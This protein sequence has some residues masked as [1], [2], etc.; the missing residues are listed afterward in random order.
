MKDNQHVHNTHHVPE[1]SEHWPP[2]KR[3]NHT[4][5][6]DEHAGH[7]TADFRKRFWICLIITIPI[8]LL[9][10]MIQDLIGLGDSIRFQGDEYLLFTFASL[11][12]FYGGFPFL[13]G[14]TREIRNKQ[15]GMMAL[16]SLAIS[17]AYIFSAAV[18]FGSP[19]HQLYWELA[20]LI[21]IMLL[22][23]WIE[24]KSI[25]GA[26]QAL[27]KLV[28]LMPSEA[29]LIKEDGSIQDIPIS[30]LKHSHKVLIKPG[31]K[32]PTDGKIIEGSS[33]VN[34]AMLTGESVPVEKKIGDD[35]FGG[36]VNGESA[37]TIQV[38]KTGNET[39]LS[40][41]IELVKQ[42][43][44]SRSK[45]QDVANRAAFFLT[46]IAL[47]VGFIT[48][49]T[50]ILIG[51]TFDFAI[52]RMVTVMVI[53][54][55]HALGLAVPLVVAVSTT[56]SASSGLL[57]RDRT[58]FE[59]SKDLSAVVF[60]KTGTLT[61][62]E[63]G[64]TDVVSLGE[65]SES[66]LLK[67]AASLESHSEHPIA[68]GIV[69]YAKQNN[70]GFSSPDSF[71]A[72]A[73]KGAEAQVGETNIKVVSP[74]YLRDKN[75]A[76]EDF[77]I[78]D[79]R[80]QT[81]TVVF[82]LINDKLAG[83]IALADIIREESLHALKNLHDLGI[84]SMMLTGDAKAVAEAVAKQLNMDDFFAEVLPHE[85]SEKIK[86][87][88]ARGLTVAMVGDGVNDAPALVEADVGIA[89]GAGTDVAIESADIIL[90]R[91]DPRDVP[92]II[93]LANA[94]Y[95]KMVQN[96]WWAAGYNIVAIP[97]AAGVLYKYGILLSPALGA[98]FMSVST[99]LVAFNAQLLWKSKNRLT[100]Q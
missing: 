26:S 64:V 11:V 71:T 40:Q 55:P 19:G 93:A 90:V 41:V 46:L 78:S 79:L 86:Q 34:Q 42:A 62:G 83:A 76:W 69:K 54:C 67:F 47:S 98:V 88:K 92:A 8:L 50:W 1:K 89:I 85:K 13:K 80:K 59:K 61:K 17:V 48:L 15:L 18:T 60:D 68:Q 72:I 82:V 9:D 66:E 39:Y 38:T 22:G 81:K 4:H 94:T 2:Y 65:Y 97:L 29:H 21:D 74:G 99:I 51:S 91:S 12:Y 73:G 56:L 95:R 58:A 14:L 63:F 100:L 84:K 24:M 36:S 44:A 87:V 30:E 10:P 31:E 70:I 96:L 53:A 75:I 52:E 3:D 6:I 20:T 7:S 33:S 35:V 32:I 45:T 28:R 43:Q 49:I 5:Q 16:I 25:L 37:I 57:I 77:K 27:E 23:H